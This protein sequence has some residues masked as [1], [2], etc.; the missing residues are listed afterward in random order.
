MYCWGGWRERGGRE[1]ESERVALVLVR[2]EMFDDVV[3]VDVDVVDDVRCEGKE[4]KKA[5]LLVSYG[6]LL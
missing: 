3:V 2:V 4:R 1:E 6:E 5:R